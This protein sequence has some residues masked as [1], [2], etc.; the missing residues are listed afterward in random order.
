MFKLVSQ[1]LATLQHQPHVCMY[2]AWRIVAMVDAI[3]GVTRDNNI[4]VLGRG[5]VGY[6][7]S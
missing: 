2:M 7:A 3:V 5:R 1:M 4:E 6:L